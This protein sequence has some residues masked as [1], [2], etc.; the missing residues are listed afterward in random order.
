M[1]LVFGDRFLGRQGYGGQRGLVTI[2]YYRLLSVT[3][4]LPKVT[5]GYRLVTEICRRG[6]WG[7][8]LRW[9]GQRGD[10]KAMGNVACGW[11]GGDMVEGHM[12]HFGYR[13]FVRWRGGLSGQPQPEGA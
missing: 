8:N 2:G 5:I 10:C 3:N 7:G 9:R 11:S 1:C 13:Q 12:R 4:W 6:Y